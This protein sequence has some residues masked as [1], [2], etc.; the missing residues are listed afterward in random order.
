MHLAAGKADGSCPAAVQPA[1]KGRQVV[2]HIAGGVL[3]GV[4]LPVS[5]VPLH[6]R[7]IAALGTSCDAMATRFQMAPSSIM[8]PKH[9]DPPEIARRKA[10]A[11]EMSA[12]AAWRDR[13]TAVVDSLSA[14]VVRTD[15]NAHF[16]IPDVPPGRY[17]VSTVWR[18]SALYWI[19]DIVV[20]KDSGLVVPLD[21]AVVRFPA[22]RMVHASAWCQR[23]TP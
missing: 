11:R 16:R 8:A 19:A 13:A 15:I 4:S 12:L 7:T 23:L 10:E 14:A 3:R 20:V 1:D 22:E 17:L 6:E 2:A 9:D 5:L 21:N 18:A